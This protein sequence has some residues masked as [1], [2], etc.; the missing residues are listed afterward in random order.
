M[1]FRL[2]VKLILFLQRLLREGEIFRVTSAKVVM[3]QFHA[4]LPSQ[5]RLGCFCAL[6]ALRDT[7]SLHCN[8]WKSNLLTWHLTP[9]HHSQ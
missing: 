9:L 2:D 1:L 8:A 5:S 3:L 7:A 4:E 6:T